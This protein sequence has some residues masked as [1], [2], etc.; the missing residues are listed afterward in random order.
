MAADLQ[1]LSGV[2]FDK[3]YAKNAGVL[4]HTKVHAALKNDI[5]SAKDPEI[6]ALVTK[7]EPIVAQHLEMAKK[8]DASIK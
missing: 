1:K 2:A 4:D 8:L 7:L 6:K 3:A 5:A